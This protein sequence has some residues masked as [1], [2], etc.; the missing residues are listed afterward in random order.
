MV[1]KWNSKT[2][3]AQLGITPITKA[4]F[5]NNFKICSRDSVL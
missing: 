1:E 3:K 4:L 5:T 2:Q